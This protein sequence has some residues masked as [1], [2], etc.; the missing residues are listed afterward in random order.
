MT[1]NGQR[2]HLSAGLLEHT[3]QLLREQ[4]GYFP[5]T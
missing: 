2:F 4:S 3:R 1:E 5:L